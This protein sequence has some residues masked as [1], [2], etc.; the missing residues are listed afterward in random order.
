[1]SETIHPLELDAIGAENYPDTLRITV[2]SVNSAFDAAIAQ[3]DV[4]VSA[5]Q[6]VRSFNN[7]ADVR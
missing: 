2:I 4:D 1:M 7:V 3:L 6:A 5:E